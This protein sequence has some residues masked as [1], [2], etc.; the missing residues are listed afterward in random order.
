MAIFTKTTTATT[1]RQINAAT[2]KTEIDNL[3]ESF[4]L[5]SAKL[6]EKA[7]E[8]DTLREIKEVEIAALQTECFGLIEV[9]NRALN[10]SEKIDNLLN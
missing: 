5:L 2:L 6:Q 4:T 9:S 1:V 3:T 7:K 10:I 8:A